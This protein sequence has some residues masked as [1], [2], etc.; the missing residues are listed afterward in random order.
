LAHNDLLVE[1]IRGLEA[2][3]E[4]L[5]TALDAVETGEDLKAVIDVY[6]TRALAAEDEVERLRALLAAPTSLV[7]DHVYREM[8][9]DNK[10]LRDA[11]LEIALAETD[12]PLHAVV[13]LQNIAADALL[14]NWKE[15]EE[16]E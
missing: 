10:R 14:L 11:L 4:A 7:P 16:S 5:R 15:E 13:G 1:E 6:L 3:E 8:K 9:A 12:D 2:R